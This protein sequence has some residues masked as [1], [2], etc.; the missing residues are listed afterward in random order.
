MP[1]PFVVRVY[2]DSLSLPRV[3]EGV[4]AAATYAELFGRGLRQRHPG[5]DV[6]LYNRAR[7][8]GTVTTLVADYLRDAGYFGRPG[9]DRLIVQCGICDCAP[10][11]IPPALRAIVGRLPAFLRGRAVGFLHEQRPRLVRVGPVWRETRPSSFRRTYAY[12]LEQVVRDCVRVYAMNVAPVTD[13]LEAHSPG[14]RASIALYNRL[15]GEAVAAVGSKNLVLLDVHAAI[16]ARPGGIE[17]CI[18]ANDGHHLTAE[19]HRLYSDLALG[20][21]DATGV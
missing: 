7:G 14:L 17:A 8:A 15:I 16:S 20:C 21:E 13:S 11:P 18:N 3:D 1:D 10:R 12:W 6:V 19:G 2:G 9:A 4:G 5:R